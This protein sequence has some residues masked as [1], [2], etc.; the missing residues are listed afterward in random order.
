[1]D[2]GC[3]TKTGAKLQVAAGDGM[4][5]ILLPNIMEYYNITLGS[6]FLLSVLWHNST[7]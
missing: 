6:L 2:S 3:R 1:M 4:V 7:H 5:T